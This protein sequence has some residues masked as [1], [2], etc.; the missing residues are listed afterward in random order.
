[1]DPQVIDVL[2]E[3]YQEVGAKEPIHVI[4]GY[5]SPATNDML[6]RRS[7]GVAKASQ[8]MVGKA[9]DFFI[10]G[11][12]LESIRN[13]GLRL[14]GGGVGF[15]PTSGSPFVHMDVG[16]VRHWPRM[17]REQLVKVFPDGRT[18]HVPTDGNPLSGY[19][20]A[21]ADLESGHRTVAPQKKRSLLAALFGG[22]QDQEETEDKAANRQAAAPEPPKRTAPAKSAPTIVAASPMKL[23][24]ASAAVETTEA[25]IPLPRTRP[26]FELAAAETRPEPAPIPRP[27]APVGQAAMV[28]LT[29]NDIITQRGYWE[30]DPEKPTEAQGR[31][32]Q[33]AS[34]SVS[35]A[36]R[37][38]AANSSKPAAAD[39][40]S[41]GSTGP[42]SRPDRV[43][44]ELALAYAAQIANPP[45]PPRLA[46]AAPVPA[47]IPNRALPAPIAGQSAASV[48]VKPAETMAQSRQ[49]RTAERLND[50]L[51]NPWLRG[52]VLARSVQ[53]GLT[54]VLFGEPDFRSLVQHMRKPDSAVM[55]TFSHDP[56]LGMTA[57][58]FTGSAVVFQATVTF[59]ERRHA[60]LR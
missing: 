3:V 25:A 50:R 32:G 52:V 23:A 17:T 7:K 19:Q 21:L 48:A 44:P 53:Y 12:P 14:H 59:E 9:V 42:F 15:Y 40:A 31:S 18:V 45:P 13:A 20:I 37:V 47:L 24:S 51:N 1:M 49:G 55:M 27:P 54:V 29:S 41:T 8:H 11:V 10:P 26:T 36:R 16:S 30:T 43:P 5:R 39:P 58:G 56:H 57:E 2:W 34:D 46:S 28:A 33:P 22:A 35:G 4:G 38:A 60:A 6:R